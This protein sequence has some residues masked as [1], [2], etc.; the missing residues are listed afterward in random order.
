MIKK[1]IHLRNSY[2]QLIIQAAAILG[3]REG[4]TAAIEDKHLDFTNNVITIDQAFVTVEGQ[5]LILKSTKSDRARKVSVPAE[6]M[7][8]FKKLRLL[9]LEQ[10]M[11]NEKFMEVART[12]IFILQ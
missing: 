6:L 11:E 1:Q 7:K 9:K 4:E 10:Q 5:G 2:W 8:A 3:A 12:S